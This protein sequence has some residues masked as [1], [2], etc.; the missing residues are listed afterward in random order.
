MARNFPPP[1]CL[2]VPLRTTWEERLQ[3]TDQNGQPL[4]LTDFQF[5]MQVRDRI[6]NALLLEVSSE[7]DY[8][9]IDL[10]AGAI[11]IS[12]PA[13]V[14]EAISADNTKVR[15]VFDSEIYLPDVP[16]YVFPLL[17]GTVSFT[18]RV[19]EVP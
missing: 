16:E 5:R 14:V 17:E 6:S 3:L 7:G 11:D 2:N 8:A 15:A 9:A 13:E 12:V 19:T 18:P 10:P 1:I 4:D